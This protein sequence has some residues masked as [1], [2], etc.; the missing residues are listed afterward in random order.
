MG[1]QSRRQRQKARRT[2]GADNPYASGG[3]NPYSTAP[4][5]SPSIPTD[6][7]V[8]APD[9]VT[10]GMKDDMGDGTPPPQNMAAM[11]V[12]IHCFGCAAEGLV[13]LSKIGRIGEDGMVLS[14]TK[15]GSTD[16]DAVDEPTITAS[17]VRQASLAKTAR[18]GDDPFQQ[19]VNKG[20]M[21][22]KS[23]PPQNGALLGMWGYYVNVPGPNGNRSSDVM[24]EDRDEAARWGA[25]LLERWPNGYDWKGD[26]E[27]QG[28]EAKRLVRTGSITPK[29]AQVW[30]LP[31]MPIWPPE[32]AEGIM[33]QVNAI[34][35][36]IQ[37]LPPVQRE[38]AARV[39]ESVLSTNPG[40]DEGL[41]WRVAHK[42]VVG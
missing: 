29:Q 21:G 32:D 40:L 34:P 20:L 11:S 26:F 41:A 3:D 31:P 12:L 35:L 8:S 22:G 1:K 15:C 23:L 38:Q 37:R 6:P 36:P 10:P 4:K 18:E 7:T 14:C 28:E 25:K 30:N 2:A 33:A 24:T 27:A 5:K 16:L 13:A 19:A 17:A 9:M 39:F 42:T